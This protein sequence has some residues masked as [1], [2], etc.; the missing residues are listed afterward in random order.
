MAN[1]ENGIGLM[2]VKPSTKM[3]MRFLLRGLEG[4]IM[5]RKT[6]GYSIEVFIVRKVII[7]Y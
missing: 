6:A 1:V 3:T 2:V 5:L 7:F 4:Y